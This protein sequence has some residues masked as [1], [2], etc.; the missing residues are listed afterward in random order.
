MPIESPSRGRWSTVAQR[1]KNGVE[2]RVQLLSN[3][4]GQEPQ[5]QEAVLLQ[6]LILAPVTTVRGRIREML[7]AVQLHGQTG[8]RAQQVHFETSRAVERDRQRH[9]EAKTTPGLRQRFQAPV[10]KRFA[11]TPC[12]VGALRV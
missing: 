10:E 4:F 1:P 6:Q 2:D 9:V 5:D 7:P 11:R 12:P 8:L 3:I